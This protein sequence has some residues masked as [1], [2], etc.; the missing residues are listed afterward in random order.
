[1]Y[2][3]VLERKL[4]PAISGMSCRQPAAS[5]MNVEVNT[6][7]IL[8]NIT[9][10]VLLEE[11]L[12]FEHEVRDGGDIEEASGTANNDMHAHEHEHAH[13]H[14]LGE[15]SDDARQSPSS[16][17]YAKSN[18]GNAN[19]DDVDDDNADD[20]RNDSDGTNGGNVADGDADDDN[21]G[22]GAD[23]AG[24]ADSGD[25]NSGS[26]G[27]GGN[28]GGDNT[29]GSDGG[30]GYKG[31]DNDDGAGD[32][33]VA[34]YGGS[35][36][37]D[38]DDGSDGGGRV[39]GSGGG[40]ASDDTATAEGCDN[41]RNETTVQNAFAAADSSGRQQ[42][43]GECVVCSIG[44]HVAGMDGVVGTI[45]DDGGDVWRL[46]NGRLAEKKNDGLK[47]VWEPKLVRQPVADPDENAWETV[48]GAQ[49]HAGIK[50]AEQDPQMVGDDSSRGS[51]GSNPSRS[52]ST[53]KKT[54]T[55]IREEVEVRAEPDPNLPWISVAP[56]DTFGQLKCYYASIKSS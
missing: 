20:G 38:N 15:D 13:E 23:D 17:G 46:E 36:G 3:C 30:G 12:A 37:G 4:L 45:V 34:A 24:G 47:R 42:S 7:F 54:A 18:R 35:R 26:G 39:G 50:R 27:G 41:V 22:N 43:I 53:T 6:H 51:S 49:R 11:D 56:L 48:E 2:V 16:I 21:G 55:H 14:I 10:Y 9:H 40:S 31:G 28:E 1:M 32:R 19:N 33:T 44:D 8:C 25:N 5:S 29:S 52:R